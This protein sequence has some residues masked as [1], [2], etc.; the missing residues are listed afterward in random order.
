MRGEHG[1]SLIETM[2]ALL[3]LSI[4][5]LGIAGVFVQGMERAMSSPGD[6]VATQ[7]AAEAIE[8]VFSARDAH[9]LTWAQIKNVDDAG[10]ED[11]VFLDGPQPMTVAGPDG[12]LN[13]ADD[14]DIEEV[15]LPGRDGFLGTDD[16]VVTTLEGY[17]RQ[18]EITEIQPDLREVTVTITYRSGRSIRTYVLQTYVSNYS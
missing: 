14:G 8:N 18:I 11:G 17:Q 1:S 7:K 4:G 13:T 2:I 5:A 9:T 10:E 15:T 12:L 3:V 16:D 6:L